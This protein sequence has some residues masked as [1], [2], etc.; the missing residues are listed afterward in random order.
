LPVDDPQHDETPRQIVQCTRERPAVLRDSRLAPRRRVNDDRRIPVRIAK[1]NEIDP[2]TYVVQI[3][4]R[5]FDFVVNGLHDIGIR[6]IRLDQHDI[7]IHAS[8]V[9]NQGQRN[10]ALA[11]AALA[12]TDH[13]DGGIFRRHLIPLKIFGIWTDRKSEVALYL[14]EPRPG[15]SPVPFLLC[16]GT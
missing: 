3:T 1:I 11:D 14:R 4:G 15:Y 16:S 13:I 8:Q 12:A 5:A 7:D 2:A 6:R 9:V 10:E